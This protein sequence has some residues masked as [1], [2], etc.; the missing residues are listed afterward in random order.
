MGAVVGGRVVGQPVITGTS[1]N[2]NFEILLDDYIIN[3]LCSEPGGG[4]FGVW[5][6]KVLIRHGR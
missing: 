5:C 6:M 1:F 4:V 2:R 3:V